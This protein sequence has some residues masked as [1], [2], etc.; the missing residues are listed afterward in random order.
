MSTPVPDEVMAR[1]LD[2][3]L[4]APGEHFD[5]LSRHLANWARAQGAVAGVALAVLAAAAAEAQGDA[6]AELATL[7]GCPMFPAGPHWPAWHA[8]RAA[9]DASPWTRGGQAPN[10]QG[11]LVLE[12]DGACYLTRVWRDEYALAAAVRQRGRAEDVDPATPAVDAAMAALLGKLFA[13]ND[14][15]QRAAA[16]AA[17]S[18]RLLLLTGPPGS[19]KTHT[20]LRA[21]LVRRAMLG[22]PLSI[23]L[24]APTG[25]AAQRIGE[26]LRQGKQALAAILTEANVRSWLD[27]IPDT[28]STL[29]R[30]LD[31]RPAQRDFARNP[32]SP[33]TADVV[34]IDEAS[35]VDLAMMRR[36]FE[37]TPPD[38]LLLLSG[39]PDQLASVA[40]GSVLADLVRA[41]GPG[42]VPRVARLTR[43]RRAVGDFGP[44]FESVQSGAGHAA[45]EALRE[46]LAWHPLPDVAALESMLATKVASGLFD[47]LLHASDPFDALALLERWQCLCALRVGPFGAIA[48]AARI[49]KLLRSRE[50]WRP[51]LDGGFHGRAVIVEQNDYGKRLFNGD[52][53][54]C[55]IDDRQ[56]VRVW[57][58]ADAPSA[59]GA[60]AT[61]AAAPG[62]ALVTTSPRSFALGEL[63]AHASAFAL[64]VHK[65]QGAE[66]DAVA[67][68]LPPQD[69]RVLG[70]ELVYTALTRARSR[71]DVHATEAVFAA[72]LARPLGRRGRLLERIRADH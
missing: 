59:N 60:V 54:V 53:G 17:G 12:S 11:A 34:A 8:W 22:R 48:V 56:R 30:L 72:A 35:M 61:H 70:R 14:G 5:A 43:S 19:G 57:F 27:E 29:H 37:A 42:E 44:L 64:T 67:L 13:T 23:A 40:A 49:E 1:V 15:D 65:A 50:G 47:P 16:L 10:P 39:D 4:A 68:V 38:A 36:V 20:L 32:R 33:L 71:V 46:R 55:L 7:A 62:S 69:A 63:P 58:A 26:A 28:A 3:A 51:T 18:G 66:Y 31:Y 21:L 24:A 6:C 9:L 52:V 41:S 25:K 45:I 2:D